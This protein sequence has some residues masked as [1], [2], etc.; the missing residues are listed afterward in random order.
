[1]II[2]ADDAAYAAEHII[3]QIEG[4]GIPIPLPPDQRSDRVADAQ[5]LVSGGRGI[6]S[7]D[8][9]DTLKEL[10]DLLGGAIA[11][12]RAN[13]EAGWIERSRQV[14]QTGNKVRPKLYIA[15]GISGTPQHK[16]GMRH[17]EH[18]IAINKNPHAPIFAIADLGVVGDVRTV[19]PAL[20]AALKKRESE[21]R[22]AEG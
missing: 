5:V 15:C 16:A 19:V 18:I 21:Q 4:W 12:S 20:I 2:R 7:A 17:A 1:M 11:S 6:H 8:Y 22:R 9:F 3:K 13:V 14:G 10:A